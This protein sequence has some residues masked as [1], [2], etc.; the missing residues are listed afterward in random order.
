[1]ERDG[2]IAGGL[3][4]RNEGKVVSG[5]PTVTSSTSMMA[6]SATA[7]PTANVEAKKSLGV[8]KGVDRVN[9]ALV[10]MGVLCMGAFML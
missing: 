3:D 2:S 1:M 4:F 5:G 9:C 8:A 6:T 7:T 10:A